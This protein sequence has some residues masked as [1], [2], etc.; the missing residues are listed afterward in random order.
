MHAEE[1]VKVK[2]G[3]LE[4]NPLESHEII[5]INELSDQ[6]EKLE[7]GLNS[8]IIEHAN[9][10]SRFEDKFDATNTMIEEE[11]LST[12]QTVQTK[13]EEVKSALESHVQTK[14]DTF[15]NSIQ[16][17]IQALEASLNETSDAL[18]ENIYDSRLV[19]CPVNNSKYAFIN[20]N[21]YYYETT[22]LNH[23]EA[24][25]NCASKFGGRSGVLFEPTTIKRNNQVS[26]F[27]KLSLYN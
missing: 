15:K 26:S 3:A 17:T 20:D 10:I 24:A 8:T 16:E 13:I 12:L 23:S 2:V 4:C 14:V 6:V 27:G 5:D 25:K 19:N 11:N 9:T 21:C 7:E 18:Y 1:M 22:N